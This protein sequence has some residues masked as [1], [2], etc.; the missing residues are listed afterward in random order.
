LAAAYSPPS[1][2]P[3]SITVVAPTV[4]PP[5]LVVTPTIQRVTPVAIPPTTI[6]EL[7]PTPT[8]EPCA[9]QACIRAAEH[10]WLERPIPI[11]SEYQYWIDQTYPYGSTQDGQREPHHGGELVNPAGTPILA[12]ADGMVVVA[13]DDSN[14]LYG[15]VPNFYGN[16]VVVQLDQTYRGQPLFTLNGHMSRIDVVVGQRVKAGDPLGAVGQTG[17]A[18]GPH[19]HFEVRIGQNDYH[20]TRN[21]ELW[22]KPLRYNGKP[23]GA[24]AG[25]VVDS[26]GIPLPELTVVIRSVEID[27]DRPI[28]RYLKTY[29][30][31]TLNGDDVLQENSALTDLPL[32]AYIV[33]VN[34]TRLYRQTITIESGRLA[35]VTFTVEPPLLLATRT[36]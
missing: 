36:P 27:F 11:A 29:A 32:G 24:P 25:R 4:A 7:S 8:A 16:L 10:F 14:T 15:L 23:W 18:I 21:P 35:W 17:I 26:A 3:P 6:P 19:T 30:A 5:A 12:A 2:L 28:V 20:S 13:G 1:T 31:E 9:D 34:T 33:S 22:L